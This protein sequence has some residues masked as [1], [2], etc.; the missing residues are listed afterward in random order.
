MQ[1]WRFTILDDAGQI[2]QWKQLILN[3]AA[4]RKVRVSGFENP[5]ALILISNDIRNK[6]GEKDSSCAAENIMLAATAYGIGSVWINALST[7]CDDETIREQ[8]RQ[9]E[10]PDRHQVY[11]MI[12]LGYPEG[13]VKSPKRNLNVVHYVK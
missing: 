11:A 3:Q 4:E 13:E 6:N 1:T 9:W 5:A 8:L 2:K 10:I 7:M 12:A